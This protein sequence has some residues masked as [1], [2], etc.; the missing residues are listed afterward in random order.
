MRNGKKVPFISFMLITLVIINTSCGSDSYNTSSKGTSEKPLSNT[1]SYSIEHKMATI[2]KGVYVSENDPTVEEF[3]LLLNRLDRECPES[4]E[5]IA[6]MIVKT[7]ELYQE[8][9]G[10]KVT[11]LWIAQQLN[12]SVPSDM[13]KSLKFAEIAAAWLVLSKN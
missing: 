2:N 12:E 9:T 10:R 13:K 1:K 6:D 7:H 8:Q 4:K 5:R 3:R 11:L